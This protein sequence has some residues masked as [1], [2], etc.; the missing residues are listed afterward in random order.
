MSVVALQSEVSFPVYGDGL[1][2]DST[3]GLLWESILISHDRPQGQERI[4][5]C[6]ECGL[7]SFVLVPWPCGDVALSAG[8]F[9]GFR[10]LLLLGGFQG[11]KK[12]Q[13]PYRIL[14]F[15]HSSG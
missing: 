14:G 12:N 11:K 10:D 4:T 13:D 9:D 5:L 6:S 2:C 8:Q 7:L 3:H 15:S 1:Y